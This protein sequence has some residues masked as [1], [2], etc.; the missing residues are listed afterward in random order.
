[1]GGPEVLDRHRHPLT[2]YAV[3]GASGWLGRA[4]VEALRARGEDVVGFASRPRDGWLA[5]DQLPE[6][7]HDVLLHYAFVTRDHL[8]SHG[9]EAFVAANVAITATVLR[10]I[11][12]FAPRMAY[13]SSGAV[14]LGDELATNPYGV[15]KALDEHV[16]RDATGGRCFVARVFNVA[17]PWITK[18]TA[19]ALTDLVGQ[20]LAGASVTI[21]A[22]RRVV[23]SFVDAEDLGALLAA[24]AGLD[25]MV[26]TAGEVEVEVG[27]LARRIL[28]ATD[29]DLPIERPPIDR[30]APADRYVG[31]A[32]AFAALCARHGIAPRSLDDQIARTV[33]SMTSRRT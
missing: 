20:A 21:S 28:R 2:R 3:T 6:V 27:E 23:R 4:A 30:A 24:T 17:G 12:R 1:V 18:P 22:R 14:H 32:V 5:L 9:L 31:D 11:A 15:L 8:R 26:D 19:F 33:A 25:E 16:F 29:R 10:A 7:K 13:A